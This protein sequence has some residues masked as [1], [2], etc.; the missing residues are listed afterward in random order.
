MMI[1]MVAPEIVVIDSAYDLFRARELRKKLSPDY[2]SGSRRKRDCSFLHLERIWNALRCKPVKCVETWS[3][4]HCWYVIMGGLRF[5]YN[6][7]V[8]ILD[9]YALQDA[10]SAGILPREPPISRA[11]IKDKSK[12]TVFVTT[13]AIMQITKFIVTLSARV[14]KANQGVHISQLELFVAGNALFSFVAYCL[15]FPKPKGVGVPTMVP[16]R[17]AH[18]REN[19]KFLKDLPSSVVFSL[20]EYMGRFPGG[21]VAFWPS[22]FAAGSGSILG[23]IHLGGWNFFFPTTTDMWIWRISSIVVTASGPILVI[24]ACFF[25]HRIRIGSKPLLGYPCDERLYTLGNWIGSIVGFTYV[26]ARVLVIV[27]MIR[28]L[29]F[30]PIGAFVADWTSNLPSIS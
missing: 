4:T 29:F 5:Q 27:E 23:L 2:E 7:E 24:S 20:H 21:E 25:T 3:T 9:E 8:R 28:C 10:I 22:M 13:I 1:I 12:S 19:D 6:N 11:E 14:S 17:E 15:Y 18:R 16:L 30:L 26:I